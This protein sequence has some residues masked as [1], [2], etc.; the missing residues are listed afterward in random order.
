MQNDFCSKDGALDKAGRDLGSTRAI[1]PGLSHFIRKAREFLVPIIFILT[2]RSR[3]EV[4]AP[5]QEIWFRHHV[6]HPACRKGSW[7]AASIEEIRPAKGDP[8]VIKKTYSAFYKTG[9]EDRLQEMDRKTLVITGVA[10]N[11]CVETTCR[12]GFMRDFYIVVPEDLVACTDDSLHK[13]SLANIDRY[14]G[15]LTSS[16]RIFEA[17]KK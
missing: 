1:I 10:T 17:W 9:L 4:P 2:E 6:E 8:V 13:A 14:F 3:E 16:E 7:G 11:V 5:M 15:Q 12:D